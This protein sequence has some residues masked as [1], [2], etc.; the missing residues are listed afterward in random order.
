MH[1]TSTQ[2]LTLLGLQ[3]SRFRDKA[4]KFQVVCPQNGN[5]SSKRINDSYK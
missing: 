2:Q 5:Y 3:Q 4:V 1:F